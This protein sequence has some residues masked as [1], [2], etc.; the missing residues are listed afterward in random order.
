MKK[1]IIYTG[2]L[3]FRLKIREIDSELPKKIYEDSEEIYHDT[4]TGYD[5]AVGRAF[6][7]DKLREMSVTYE[8]TIDEIK[9]ITIHPLRIYEKISKIKSGRWHKL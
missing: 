2:H 7:K 6:Y 9:I 8:E 5:I 4:K 3:Q 1:E